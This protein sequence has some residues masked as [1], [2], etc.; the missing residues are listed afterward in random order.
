MPVLLLSSGDPQAKTLLRNAVDARYGFRPPALETLHLHFHGRVQSKIGPLSSWLNMEIQARFKFPSSLHWEYT[1]R[2]A[3]IAVRQGAE[4]YDG[5][6]YRRKSGSGILSDETDPNVL[7]SFQRRL[8]AVSAAL[9]MPLTEQA[10]VLKSTGGRT[11]EATHR[12]TNNTARLTLAPDYA[13]QSVQIDCFNAS[14]GKE[15]TFKLALSPEK[16]ALGDLI[17]PAKIL[18]AWDREPMMELE[19]TAGSMNTM[20]TDRLFA[21]AI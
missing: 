1:V 3:G 11:F 16:I 10:V 14:E 8:W 20:L 21:L 15:Q 7:A 4:A 18:A 5:V 9:L 2:A 13:L 12:E 19:P 17:L 6:R